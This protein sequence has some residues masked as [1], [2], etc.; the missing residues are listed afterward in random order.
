MSFFKKLFKSEPP[1]LVEGNEPTGPLPQ[2]VLMKTNLG[3]IELELHT[4]QTPKVYY[5]PR[6]GGALICRTPLTDKLYLDMPQLRH[7]CQCGQIR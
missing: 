2:R 1:L 3:D 6:P 7:A 5:A 4:E